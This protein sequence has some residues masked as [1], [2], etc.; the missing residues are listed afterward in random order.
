ME[1]LWSPVV[2]T[3]GNQWQINREQKR[4][5]Q[6][7]SVA[8][9]CHRSPERFMVRRGLRFE[10]GRGLQKKA[11]KWPF[12]LP[13]W[14]TYIVRASLNLPEDLSP[15]LQGGLAS[16][17]KQ[18]RLT[19]SSTSMNRRYPATEGRKDIDAPDTRRSTV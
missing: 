16:W 9:N 14:R 18:R 12:L 13:R 10:S 4:L 3:G 6:A 8:T 7:K 1:P 2:A 15:T 5:K 19:S 17:L 11:G